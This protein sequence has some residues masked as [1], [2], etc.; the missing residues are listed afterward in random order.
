MRR[1][2]GRSF[3]RRSQS[4]KLETGSSRRYNSSTFRVRFFKFR[5]VIRPPRLR[6]LGITFLGSV[7]AL[8]GLAWVV[9]IYV[10]F[11]NADDT[12]NLA[13]YREIADQSDQKSPAPDFIFKKILAYN[14]L[15]TKVWTQYISTLAVTDRENEAEQALEH[16]TSE[17]KL[18]DAGISLR[19]A[20]QLLTDGRT[21]P[22]SLAKAERLLRQASQ[23]GGPDSIEARRQLAMILVQ[24]NDHAGAVK[25]LTPVM[26]ESPVA[27]SEA[28][29]IGFTN[30]QG[31]D[32]NA[33]N[34]IMQRVDRDIRASG[35]SVPFNLVISKVRTL[36]LL[37][38][39]SEA[40]KWLS[41]QPGISDDVR[42][43]VEIES[44]E[45]ALISSMVRSGKERVPEWSKLEA[46]LK[47]D[48]DH[49]IWT[50]VAV[51]VWAGPVVP[52]SEPTRVWVQKRIDDDTAGLNLIKN[53]VKE[54]AIRYNQ[55]GESSE[56]SLIVRRL[57][58]KLL[59]FE[60]ENVIALNNLAMLM[61]KYEKDRLPEALDLARKADR[62]SGGK[63]PAI[64]DTIGQILARMGRMDEAQEILEQC[65]S[66]LPQEWNLHN[67]LAQIYERRGNEDLAQAHR[68]AMSRIPRPKD[69]ANYEK[70]FE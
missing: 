50:A 42:Q 49:I 24:R 57:Y 36:I 40:R 58:R 11:L 61:Y 44:D 63:Q 33:A 45:M 9:S 16:L 1:S 39:E 5:F 69:S 64:R 30:G 35:A 21:T 48:P 37:D 68:L 67:T 3:D 51:A 52:G 10:S 53:A 8:L 56:D 62:L 59:N 6:R 2:R 55:T 32:R 4:D 26:S 19:L 46:V 38:Q 65:V 15:D 28:L 17:V 7:P 22:V 47:R 70:L 20:Q 41:V 31:L 66:E 25:L 54:M 43:A 18:N 34:R 14:L 23:Q 12:I 29:W 60:P 13:G 27:G